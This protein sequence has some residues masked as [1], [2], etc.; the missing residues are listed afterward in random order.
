ML[1]FLA[2]K[3]QSL[4]HFSV[5]RT[6]IRKHHMESLM[7]NSTNMIRHKQEESQSALTS[8]VNVGKANKVFKAIALFRE[9]GAVTVR[10]C[11][12]A[13]SGPAKMS[14]TCVV[15]TAIPSRS[16]ETE[17]DRAEI[18]K[19]LFA[20][21]CSDL[22]LR[23]L[24]AVHRN[25]DQLVFDGDDFDEEDKIVSRI[26]ATC[27]VSS[28]AWLRLGEESLLNLLS[29]AAS[30]LGSGFLFRKC[31]IWL[32]APCIV[33]LFS[34]KTEDLF[35]QE[36]FSKN[37]ETMK[38]FGMLIIKNA[39]DS[40]SIVDLHEIVR[41]RIEQ[42][43]HAVYKKRPDLRLGI[44]LFAFSEFSSRGGHR[45]DLLF[46]EEEE[47]SRP[48]FDIARSGPWIPIITVLL[49]DNFECMASVVYSRPGSEAQDWHTD[50]A[51]VGHSEG[52]DEAGFAA[53]PPYALC[54]FVAMVDLDRTVGF[55]QFW[56]G[57]HR[58]A[59]LAGF[60]G[61][62]PVLGCAVD[63]L[64]PAGGCVI[65]DYRLMHRGMPNVSQA[66]KR[67]VL[68][69]LYHLPTYK[70]TKNYGQSKLF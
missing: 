9:I 29:T 25:P 38:E 67:P 6:R 5:K 36:D 18:K 15:V 31:E 40:D 28:S 3:P 41:Q 12:Y 59:E 55:T 62:A 22:D 30:P 66:T 60:G 34:K 56:P 64:V 61:A 11:Q 52:W 68:Q 44:D 50:G 51:H 8:W 63:G 10:N 32:T 43:E 58:Y 27:S 26:I 19:W 2:P 4:E 54:V 48:I 35:A 21:N 70:E 45:F 47:I 14:K 7:F 65:Y 17:P 33:P 42:A 23:W 16:T 69:L 24:N 39:L 37:F 20:L 53:D 57:T 13:G 46:N 49:G 1:V